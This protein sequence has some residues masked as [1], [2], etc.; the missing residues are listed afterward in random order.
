MPGIMGSRLSV[1]NHGLPDLVRIDP[2]DMIGGGL[3]ELWPAAADTVIAATG[4]VL[5]P[6]LRLRLRLTLA[7]YDAAFL[8]YGWRLSPAATGAALLGQMQDR[9][10][11]DVALVGHSMGG[12]VARAMAGG[13]PYGSVVSQ[14]IT[15][16]TPNHGSYAPLEVL[17]LSHGSLRAIASVDLG[18]TAHDIASDVL[19]HMPGLLEM[20]PDPA[21][22]A[23]ADYFA[24][25]SWPRRAVR[26]LKAALGAA[27]AGAGSLA[28]PDDRFTQIVGWSEDTIVG[29]SVGDD[30]FV[31]DMKRDGDGTVPRDLAETEGTARYYTRGAHGSLCNRGDVIA[32]V[33]DLIGT[34]QTAQLPQSRPLVGA[35]S[36]TSHRVTAEH[37][38]QQRVKDVPH[39]PLR[40]TDFAGTFLSPGY[41]TDDITDWAAKDGGLPRAALIGT[42]P[43][44][45]PCCNYPLNVIRAA[46]TRWD[47]SK[48]ERDR[49]ATQMAGARPLE[50]ESAPRLVAY[51]ER[52]LTQI[53][54]SP[55]RPDPDIVAGLETAVR[56]GAQASSHAV[57]LPAA[58]RSFLER[59]IGEAE[60]FL[61]VM[62][63]KRAVV[64]AASVGRIVTKDSRRGFGTGFLIAPGILMT[65][66]H[67]LHTMQDAQAASVQFMFEL[68]VDSR[69]APGH[70]FELEPDRLFHAD[71][72]LDMA[73]VAVAPTA[74]DGTLLSDCGQLPLI[75]AEGKI[76]K[77]Q[78]VNIVQHPLGGRKQ[79]VFRE[80]LLSALP[81][82]DDHV[83]HY[84]GD[85]QPGS[86]GSPVFSDRWEV[87]ALHH[88]GVPAVNSNGQIMTMDE[89][90]WD[91]QADPGGRTIKWVANEGIRISRI[92]RHLKTLPAA[93]EAQG[94]PGADLVRDIL[95]ISDEATANGAFI[96][97]SPKPRPS[98]S[99]RGEEAAPAVRLYGSAATGLASMAGAG[100]AI[101]PLHL[102]I[103]ISLAPPGPNAVPP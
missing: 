77:G 86:S 47:G 41:E 27:R 92:I 84:T 26:P 79:V 43:A 68:E 40:E 57:Q 88:S 75:G 48:E 4:T 25:S 31:F 46:R 61:S 95:R 5:A 24:P 72:A 102:T 53:K 71:T 98:G 1:V 9:G 103:G 18:S 76:R 6:Y 65:N 80:S 89:T 45:G 19:R 30:G 55:R 17:S 21:K 101:I 60:D 2:F 99:P 16:G 22:R 97:T 66:Q 15:A 28:P 51:T 54:A 91:E 11:R 7:G 8:P 13:D 49:V 96:H 14:V 64:A 44:P 74:L 29:A 52:L 56:T 32:A 81:Q 70:I 78:P 59:I 35:E 39:P 10:F 37:L 12:L 42:D 36:L 58:E 87:I 67:V 82:D 69:E 90:V 83:A 94:A 3:R 38:A 85:T 23:D 63:V 100:T 50:T 34:G 20:L 93:L 62:F 33:I 73:I